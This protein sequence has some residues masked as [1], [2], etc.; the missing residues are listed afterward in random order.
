M[1]KNL[2]HIANVKNVEVLCKPGMY[3]TYSPELY[4][5]KEDELIEVSIPDYELAS[6]NGEFLINKE[7]V[8]LYPEFHEVINEISDELMEVLGNKLVV[9]KDEYSKKLEEIIEKHGY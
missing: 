4:F 8:S 5:K 3:L 1:S 9:L 7:R 2:F 6:S